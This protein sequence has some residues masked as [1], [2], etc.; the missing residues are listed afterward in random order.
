MSTIV[1][2]EDDE[3]IRDCVE[4]KATDVMCAQAIF[5][6]EEIRRH[7][8]VRDARRTRAPFYVT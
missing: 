6:R 3:H 4:E 1:I 5:E 7:I 2:E 8:Q